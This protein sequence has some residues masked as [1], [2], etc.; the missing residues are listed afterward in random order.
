MNIN[1]NYYLNNPRNITIIIYLLIILLILY[2]KPNIMF[3]RNYKIK[4][5]GLSKNNTLIP[6]YFICIILSIILYYI[7]SYF[8][9]LVNS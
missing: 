5:L 6:Y 3:D 4:K 2:I 7:V 1:L 8:F 9:K